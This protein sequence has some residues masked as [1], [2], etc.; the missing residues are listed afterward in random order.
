MNVARKTFKGRTQGRVIGTRD[1]IYGVTKAPTRLWGLALDPRAVIA[2]VALL[3]LGCGSRCAAPF[4]PK[5]FPKATNRFPADA[6][7]DGN[8]QKHMHSARKTESS[9]A[10]ETRGKALPAGSAK[11]S[12]RFECDAELKAA[13]I[14]SRHRNWLGCFHL[15]IDLF[16]LPALN[17]LLRPFPFVATLCISVMSREI[18]LV[19]VRGSFCINLVHRA[20]EPLCTHEFHPSEEPLQAVSWER[21]RAERIVKG[22]P[23]RRRP[24]E[25]KLMSLR[26]CVTQGR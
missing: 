16:D 1:V 8:R 9:R 20:R 7:C 5:P 21:L 6:K 17:K 3:F 14:T 18:R 19:F 2:R 24:N 23:R 26:C 12:H 10:L 15:R 25:R 22:S 13:L 11:C 4:Q